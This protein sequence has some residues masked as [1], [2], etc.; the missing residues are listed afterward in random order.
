MADARRYGGENAHLRPTIQCYLHNATPPGGQI[1]PPPGRAFLETSSVEGVVRDGGVVELLVD[2]DQDAVV[3]DLAGVD[4]QRGH[5]GDADGL[6][7]GQV[8]MWVA[9]LGDL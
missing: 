4:G 6:A 2:V 1:I 8:K 5:H 3:F 7:G 9:R